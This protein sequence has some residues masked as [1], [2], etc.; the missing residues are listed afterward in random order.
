MTDNLI[1][2]LQSSDIKNIG[3]SD[4]SACV[5]YLQFSNIKRGQSYYKMNAQLFTDSKYIELMKTKIPLI[6]TKHSN[7]DPQLQ[8]EM[9]KVEISE[10][11]QQYSRHKSCINICNNKSDIDNL[12]LLEKELTKN[13]QDINT[14]QKITDIKKRLEIRRIEETKAA[15]VRSGIKWIENGE[16]TRNIFF[17]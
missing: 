1:P 6:I 7:L 15:Q 11:S 2:F 12:N 8:W 16:K 17:L 5:S 3:F 13:P 9:V 4:H 14:I 10:I